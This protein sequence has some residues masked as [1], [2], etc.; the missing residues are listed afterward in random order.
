MRFQQAVL[1]N[2]IQQEENSIRTKVQN[3]GLLMQQFSN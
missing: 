2:Q 3:A 1:Q